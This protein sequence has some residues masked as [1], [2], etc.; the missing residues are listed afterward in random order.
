MTDATG[1]L[2]H[3]TYTVPNFAEGYC[4]D[5]NARALLLTVLLGE[6]GQEGPEVRRVGTASAGAVTP[7]GHHEADFYRAR[8]GPAAVETARRLPLP[9]RRPRRGA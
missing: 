4:T 8:S 7:T 5:D 2:Q 1:I 9:G 6:V 3:A